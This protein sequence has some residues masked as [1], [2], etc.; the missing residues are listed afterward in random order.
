MLLEDLQFVVDGNAFLLQYRVKPTVTFIS[1]HRPVIVV[2]S[3]CLH[4]KWFHFMCRTN[5][6]QKRR[7]PM[8]ALNVLRQEGIEKNKV[9]AKY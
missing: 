2:V 6:R 9:R 4:F 8:R 1:L 7:W 5:L 3:E